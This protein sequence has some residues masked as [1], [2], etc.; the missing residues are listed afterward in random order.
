MSP[1][2]EASLHPVTLAY[3]WGPAP[4]PPRFFAFWHPD[5]MD[6]PRSTRLTR[7]AIRTALGLLPWTTVNDLCAARE[8]NLDEVFSPLGLALADPIRHSILY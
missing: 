2:A 6:E 7:N 1:K 5:E 4:R 3:R 8:L